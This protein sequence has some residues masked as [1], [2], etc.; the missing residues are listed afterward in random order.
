LLLLCK[1]AFFQLWRSLD[2]MIGV[3]LPFHSVPFHSVPFRSHGS[4]SS[5]SSFHV[6]CWLPPMLFRSNKI[7]NSVVSLCQGHTCRT[8]CSLSIWSPYSLYPAMALLS[9]RPSLALQ[10]AQNWVCSCKFPR[11]YT[12]SNRS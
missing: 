4:F 11:I 5:S 8:C 12:N 3:L 9:L 6:S 1:Y 7:L 2:N 10:F